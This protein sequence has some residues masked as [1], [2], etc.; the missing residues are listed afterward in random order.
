MTFS[1]GGKPFGAP[2]VS[3]S[4]LRTRRWNSL[5]IPYAAL[6]CCASQKAALPVQTHV[7][8]T[9]SCLRAH[10]GIGACPADRSQSNK[11]VALA[12]AG[13]ATLA[14]IADADEPTLR[15]VDVDTGREIATTPLRG[16]PEQVMVLNDGRVAV[17]LRSANSV[18][19]L[20]PSEP[21]SPL[22]SRC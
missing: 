5:F 7:A 3:L 4:M 15:T 18:E 16:R 2:S 20:E 14:Y 13:K 19:I 10:P 6:L 21:G 22:E 1:G 9:Q 17:T 11:T 8:T 12:R